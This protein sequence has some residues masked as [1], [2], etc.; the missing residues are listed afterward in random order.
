MNLSLLIFTCFCFVC[1]RIYSGKKSGVL[2]TALRQR[3]SDNNGIEVDINLKKAY[4]NIHFVETPFWYCV[5]LGFASIL[6]YAFN[7]LPHTSLGI[8]LTA[9]IL[10]SYGCSAV[11]GVFYQGY[12]NLGNTDVN[13]VPLKFIDKNEKR[14]M[15]LALSIPWFSLTFKPFK[16]KYKSINLV[17]RINRFWRGRFRIVTSILGLLSVIIG[18]ILVS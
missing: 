1:I 4:D 7:Q 12:I 13:G 11:A 16:V 2:Y 14:Y 5:Y 10:I 9:A 18:I 3:S 17:Y 8:N 15:E 6:L